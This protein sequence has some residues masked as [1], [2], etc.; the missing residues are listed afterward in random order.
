M[1]GLLLTV[2]P[3]KIAGVPSG[4]IALLAAGFILAVTIPRLWKPAP[5]ARIWLLAGLIGLIAVFYFQWRIPHPSAHDVS[6]LISQV[7]TATPAPSFNVRGTIDTVPKLTRKQ[8]I[9]FVLKASLAGR[10]PTQ[11]DVPIPEK[12]SGKLYVTVPLLQGTG[13]APGQPVIVTGRFYQPKPAANPGGFDFEAYLAQEGIFAGMTATRVEIPAG[14]D[15]FPSLVRTIRRSLHKIRQRIVRSQVSGLGV[16]EG[17]LASAMFL[18]Q[19]GVDV[20][21]DVRDTFARAGLAHALAASGS[22]VSLLIGV[23]LALTKRLSDKGRFAVGSGVLL[24]YI[25]L[26]GLQP[27]ILRAALMG[28][29]ALLALTLERK[30]KPLGSILLAAMVLL[31]I[32]PAWIFDL[33]FQLSFLATLGLLVT[34]PILNKWLDWM[35]VAIAP[36][37]SVPLAAYIWTLPLM[38][39]T[40]GVVSPYSI[41]VNVLAVPLITVISI[42]SGINALLALIYPPLGSMTASLLYYPTHA[43]I[44]LAEFGNHLPGNSFATGTISGSQLLVLYGFYGCIWW[45]SQYRRYWWIVGVM[46]IGL[47]AIPAWHH[48]SSLYQVTVLATSTKPVLLVQNRGEIL[49]VGSGDDEDVN[50]TVLPFLKQQGINQIN[51]AIAPDL[52]SSSAAGWLRLL[53][54]LPIQTFYGKPVSANAD[55]RENYLAHLVLNALSTKHYQNVMLDEQHIPQMNGMQTRLISATPLALTVQIGNQRWLLLQDSTP[56]TQQTL[57]TQHQLTP[58]DTIWWS[59]EALSQSLLENVKPKVAIASTRTI[60]RETTKLLEDYGVTT[61]S[62]GRDGAIQWTPAQGFVA[63]LGENDH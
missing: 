11:T 63:T 2:I 31:I 18:G 43:L 59:G 33:G 29:A 56:A 27:S 8:R 38:L 16:P 47:V 24:G 54:N 49:L 39:W 41:P 22:Q 13:L 57:A 3:H 1:L 42:G 26:A 7:E 4:A 36:L 12:V 25:G 34:V 32:K 20:P 14:A 30:V 62:T 40:F 23:V 10:S 15:Q 45:Q 48:Y 6:H 35:P 28:F 58:V 21:Y 19:N 52:K 53:Q 37:I 46:C 55:L 61:Y 44:G 9:Q 17:P 5:K 60:P 50:Y 51:W